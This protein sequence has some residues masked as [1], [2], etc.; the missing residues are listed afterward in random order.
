MA[1]SPL[2]W[3]GRHRGHVLGG[4]VILLLVVAAVEGYWLYERRTDAPLAPPPAL[5]HL[6]RPVTHLSVRRRRPPVSYITRSRPR[7]NSASTG[8]TSGPETRRPAL[9]QSN[10][11]SW[12]EA[13]QM[14]CHDRAMAGR[15]ICLKAKKGHRSVSEQ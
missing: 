2:A 8:S 13:A 14:V 4:A 10:C 6:P 1:E 11:R 5:A 12:I 9:C 7:T 15:V 3:L